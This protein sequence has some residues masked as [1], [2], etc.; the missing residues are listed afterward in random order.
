MNG[1]FIFAPVFMFDCI[2]HWG[3]TVRFFGLSVSVLPFYRD[4]G[5]HLDKTETIPNKADKNWTKWT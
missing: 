4:A 1:P 5:K 3:V 2:D